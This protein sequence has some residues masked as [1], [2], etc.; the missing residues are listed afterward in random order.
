M[1]TD[2]LYTVLKEYLEMNKHQS[3]HLV[4]QI[5][6]NNRNFISNVIEL[7]LIRGDTINY[8]I[9][10]EMIITSYCI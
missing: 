10:M 3:R 5:D 4:I 7:I 6:F 9:N 2:V 8:I 1:A